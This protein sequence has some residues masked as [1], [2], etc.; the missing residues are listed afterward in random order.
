MPLTRRDFFRISSMGLVAGTLPVL[1][2]P[3]LEGRFVPSGVHVPSRARHPFHRLRDLRILRR[4][5]GIY[6]AQGGTIG[7]LVSG[8]GSLVVD[9]QFPD[10]ARRFIELVREEGA[11]GFEALVNTHH[12]GDHTSGNAVFRDS[13]R[14]IVAHAAARRLHAEAAGGDGGAGVADETFDTSWRL[15]VGDEVVHARHYGPAHTGGDCTV[16]FQEAN[17]V[18]MGDLVFNRLH[19]FIDRPA[20]ASI[21]G[22]ISLLDTVVAEHDGDALYVFGHGHPDFGV[23]G[24]ARDVELQARYLEALLETADRGIREGRSREE[25]M[26][27]DALPGFPDH[28][29]PSERLTLAAALGVAFDE[30]VDG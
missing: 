6:T 5:V 21:R 22:W 15:E 28:R 23:T 14:R 13:T 3:G 7:W 9:S 2:P 19:P 27:L 29:P 4:N 30:L 24:A 1:F 11:A 12:H 26:D 20:G 16:H 8:D 17:V 25:V 18:H 10:P